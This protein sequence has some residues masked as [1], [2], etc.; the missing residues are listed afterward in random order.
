VKA[1]VEAMKAFVGGRQEFVVDNVIS[2]LYS[3]DLAHR[4]R[5]VP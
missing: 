2:I 4:T 1:E 5:E 3:R